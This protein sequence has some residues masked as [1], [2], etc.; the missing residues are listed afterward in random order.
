[1]TSIAGHCL[2][3]LSTLEIEMNLG[4][5]GEADTAMYLQGAFG[6]R[7]PRSVPRPAPVRSSIQRSVS[8]YA[9]Q[10]VLGTPEVLIGL[11]V[12]AEHRYP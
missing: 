1:M 7:N 8:A 3:E 5:P 10:E 6:D 11:D 12:F 4:F 2:V 9:V